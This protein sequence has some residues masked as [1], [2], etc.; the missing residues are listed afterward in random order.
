MFTRSDIITLRQQVDVNKALE[1]LTMFKEAG[2]ER[3]DVRT[4]LDE[5]ALKIKDYHALLERLKK[6]AEGHETCNHS[7]F[8]A[9][10]GV[11]RQTVYN[12]KDC[13]YLM[14]TGNKVNLPATL[15]LWTSLP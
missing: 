1:L 10:L 6:M 13:N 2:N 12:W 14:Y 4:L 5:A 9:W 15:E 8:A 11:S 7:E 3:I